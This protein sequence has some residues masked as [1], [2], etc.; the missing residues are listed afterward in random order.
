MAPVALTF[1]VIHRGGG[2]SAIGWVLGAGTA[3][4][5]LFLL[6]GGVLGDRFGR[7]RLMCTAD[8]AR[9]GVQSALGVGILTAHPPIWVFILLEFLVG[10]GDALYVPSMTGLVP[11]ITPPEHLGRANA[12]NALSWTSGTLIGPAIG[13][14]V[15]AGF[16]AGWAVC[17]DGL[18]YLLSA[19]L[20]STIRLGPVHRGV[21]V[22]FLRDLGTGWAEFRSRVWLWSIVLQFALF[23]L[24]CYTPFVVLGALIAHRSLG[25]AGAW[26]AIL[27]AVGAGSVVGGLLMLRQRPRY[28]LRLAELG[29]MGWAAPLLAL[30]L[31]APTGVIAAAGAVAGLGLGIFGPLWD[32][33][34]QREIPSDV[35]S[36]VSSYD[37]LGSVATLPLGFIVAGPIAGVVG[38]RTALVGGAVVL[39]GSI[40][41]VLSFASVRDLRSDLVVPGTVGG[42]R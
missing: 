38:D 16:G 39:L 10:T 5:V 2:A 36:R 9:A 26:G 15:V 3:P 41:G 40:A 27:S 7:K 6:A 37:W 21:G 23:H 12:L 33:T 18:S 22:G 42:D 35:L 28:P 11:A 29:M 14:L 25:G 19:I 30:G 32:A 17:A 1:A 20:L 13:G 24:L 31:G 8:F 34:M 4:L